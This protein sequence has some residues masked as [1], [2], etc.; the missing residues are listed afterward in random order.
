MENTLTPILTAEARGS[1][2]IQL[3]V[4]DGIV[5]SEPDFVEISVGNTA[6]VARAGEDAFPHVGDTL[7]L[8]GTASGDADGDA[9]SYNWS[10]VSG[11]PDGILLGDTTVARPDIEVLEQGEYELQLVVN[12]G[13]IDSEADTVL[14]T[15][16]NRT[17]IAD[18]GADVV[19]NVGDEIQ[20][21]GSGSYD[22]DGDDIS[23]SWS[24]VDPDQ[25]DG[26][27]L[28]GIDA[29]QL[30]AVINEQG[31]YILQLVVND[32]QSDSTAD[33]VR[34]SVGNVA[35]VANAGNDQPVHIGSSTILDGSNSTDA[36]GDALTYRWSVVESSEEDGIEL[37]S[38]TDVRPAVQVNSLGFYRIQLIVNDGFEDSA[39][40]EVVLDVGN[41][42]PV[43]DAGVDQSG[44]PGEAISLN[45]EN[46]S[47]IDGDLLTY[48]WSV[49]DA[50][51]GSASDLMNSD[52]FNASFIPDV[53]GQYT[54]QLVVNDGYADSEPD[55]MTIDSSNM[56]PVANAGADTSARLE[57]IV[58]LS[59]VGSSDAE[60]DALS[61][62]WSVISQP[63]DTSVTLNDSDTVTPSF[64]MSAFGDYVVQL[65]VNDGYQDSAPDV[66]MI[67]S[68]NVAPIADAGSDLEIEIEESVSLSGSGSS[69]PEGMALTY[70]W[71]FTNLP[72]GVDLELNDS[73]S[74]SPSFVPDM[75]GTY[76]VQLTVNDGEFTDS[77][78]VTV[79]VNEPEFVCDTSDVTRKS[80]PAVIRDFND[81]HPDFEYVI[82]AEQGIVANDLGDDGLP[83]YANP[84]GVTNTTNGIDAFNQWYRDVDGVNQRIPMEFDMVINDEGD[85]QYKNF[86]FFPIDD[87]GWGNQ[88]RS[89]NYHFTL[90]SHLVFDYEGDEHFMFAGD[91]DLWVFINGKLAIDIGGVHSV[92][93]REI[94]L[95]DLAEQLGIEPGN[96][97]SFDLFFAERHTVKSTFKFETSINLECG[98]F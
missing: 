88:G 56:A 9:I 69:D 57:Q 31:D 25:A 79:I 71:S 86:D 90:E 47:D 48:S 4:S 83:V 94:Y 1:F 92:E 17:P 37:L 87:L 58:T 59:G 91:D 5:E 67:T 52:N 78:T 60:N 54:I 3:V 24:I 32:G 62:S 6:P 70:Q 97:Y 85:W 64:E 22:P 77:D 28:S 75:A 8:D 55:V 2:T 74:I 13:D 33:Q 35:P 27:T 43:A 82:G 10:I 65:I 53:L 61:Y 73:S 95:P 51:V 7:N 89:H 44:F 66:V 42:R 76:I 30:N 45:G 19:V 14:L 98:E 50:P 68:E 96:R 21:D 34:I 72:D 38:S 20:L 23:F 26:L 40:D 63:A 16:N 18:T 11:S 81:S 46:S 80:F 84:D 12:D 39:A 15:V 41:I 36:D 29:E 93:A 49:I